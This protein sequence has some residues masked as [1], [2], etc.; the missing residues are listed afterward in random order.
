MA[1]QLAGLGEHTTGESLRQHTE[2]HIYVQTVTKT[3]QKT[4][5]QG[6]APFKGKFSPEM[7]V[8]YCFFQNRLLNVILGLDF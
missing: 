5:F 3:Q 4:E 6:N 1:W 7:S 8:L 2:C